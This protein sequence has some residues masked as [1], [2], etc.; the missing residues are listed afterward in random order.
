[1]VYYGEGEFRP[2]ECKDVVDKICSCVRLKKT[3]EVKDIINVSRMQEL[4]EIKEM[5]DLKPPFYLR[6]L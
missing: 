5:G 3:T 1:M 4:I 2:I 6:R